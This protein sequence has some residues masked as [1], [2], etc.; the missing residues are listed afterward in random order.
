MEGL[1]EVMMV[2][3][4]VTSPTVRLDSLP[5]AEM[6]QKLL[7][8]A[9]SKKAESAPKTDWNALVRPRQLFAEKSTAVIET[10]VGEGLQIWFGAKD[11]KV[12]AHGMMAGQSG[13]GKSSL[14]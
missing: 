7:A 8:A 1:T 6:V 10:P 14:L 4:S 11:G 3:T 12:C 2:E 5:S 13:S 9:A